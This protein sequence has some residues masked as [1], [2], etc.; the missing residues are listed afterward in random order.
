MH[1]TRQSRDYQHNFNSFSWTP[2][3]IVKTNY[4][5]SSEE[6]F[7]APYQIQ[8]DV[9]RLIFAPADNDSII[10]RSN[11]AAPTCWICYETEQSKSNIIVRECACRG[12]ANGFV[13]VD[14]LV[15]LAI[16]KADNK[17]QEGIDDENP[18]TQCITCKQEFK[19]DSYSYHYLAAGCFKAFGGDADIGKPWNGV[20]SSMI[21]MAKHTAGDSEMA[22]KFLLGRCNIL[23]SKRHDKSVQLSCNEIFQLDLDFAR[24]LGDLAL[25]YEEKGELDDMKKILDYSL[26]MIKKLENGTPSRRKVNILS[27]LATHACLVGNTSAAIERYE[28]C[29]SLTRGQA[30]ES[31]MLLATLLIKSGNL[32]LELGNTERGIEQF[33]ESVDIMKVVYGRDHMKVVQFAECLDNIQKG[34]LEKIPKT[35]MSLDFSC[36][37]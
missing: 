19:K 22:M 34:L 6:N 14:C 12:E 20:A 21:A 5:V 3:T 35:L 16:A 4:T 25:V 17:R 37:L 32:E 10:R 31:D 11:I 2:G 7:V 13:H 24:L 33:S 27:S 30:K 29:I 8:L 36:W 23:Q 1:S 15:K 28:E 26:F 18:F 9:G